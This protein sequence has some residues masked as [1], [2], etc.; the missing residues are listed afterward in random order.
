MGLLLSVIMYYENNIYYCIIAHLTNNFLSLTLSY[1][2]I[3][4]IFNHWTYILLA[5]ILCVVFLAIVLTF[6]FKN[7]K[8]IEKQKLSKSNLIYLCVSLAIVFIILP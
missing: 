1:A 6:T 2:K 3:N 4:L 5:I 8:Q 7:N